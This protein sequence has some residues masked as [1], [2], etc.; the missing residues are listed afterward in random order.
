VLSGRALA[1]LGA[2]AALPAHA[3]PRVPE[4]EASVAERLARSDF[5]FVWDL[6]A[7]TIGRGDPNRAF[8]TLHDGLMFAVTEGRHGIQ[9]GTPATVTLDRLPRVS[10]WDEAYG[11]ELRSRQTALDGSP[12]VVHVEVMRRDCDKGRTQV[13]YAL[14]LEPRTSDNWTELRKA[15]SR[16][17]CDVERSK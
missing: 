4:L 6:D 8:R 1:A 3:E 11:G 10:G 17:F 12:L 9:P 14:S 5:A 13:F 16:L 2:I 7:G 15:G